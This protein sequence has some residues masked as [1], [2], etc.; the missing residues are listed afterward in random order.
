MIIF[1]ADTFKDRVWTRELG[2]FAIGLASLEATSTKCIT[3]SVWTMNK[4]S[5][6]GNGSY[7]S[8]QY[9]TPSARVM[10]HLLR[11][12]LVWTLLSPLVFVHAAARIRSLDALPWTFSRWMLVQDSGQLSGELVSG[13]LMWW[14]S[15][16][17]LLTKE[18]TT[19]AEHVC[20]ESKGKSDVQESNELHVDRLSVWW[21]LFGSVWLGCSFKERCTLV[22]EEDWFWSL[23]GRWY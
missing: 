11:W 17:V 19:F 13:I 20:R 23:V 6:L 7:F 14:F 12:S 2:D 18:A 1:V 8:C 21:V 15:Y 3:P 5:P 9:S 22:D 10:R 16:V 4:Q